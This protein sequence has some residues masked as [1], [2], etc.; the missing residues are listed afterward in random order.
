MGK[1][2]NCKIEMLEIAWER[3]Y[4]PKCRSIWERREKGEWYP[5]T[6]SDRSRSKLGDTKE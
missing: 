4:C 5:R 1:C 6:T 2:P 3:E